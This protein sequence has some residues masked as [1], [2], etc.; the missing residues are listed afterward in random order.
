MPP[1]ASSLITSSTSATSSGSS[2]LVT[3]SSSMICGCMARARTIATRCCWPPDSRSGYSSC[4]S[5]RPNRL[6][7]SLACA[8]GLRPR[9]PQRLGRGQRHVPQHGHVREQVEGLEDDA[10]LAPDQVL[11]DVRPGDLVPEHADPPGVD[12]L[13]QVDA[14][15]QRRLARARRADQADDLVRGH[16]Q[17][18][19]LEHLVGLEGLVQVLDHDGLGRRRRGRARRLDLG[20]AHAVAPASRRRRSRSISRSVNRASG[21]VRIRNK[22]AATVKLE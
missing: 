18:D 13:Q 21:M 1:W 8:C 4:L 17:V 6:S 10:D 22:I 19:A 5:A 7:S 11:V 20:P 9:H 14:A 16:R 3:S 12:G 15:Q 2:A